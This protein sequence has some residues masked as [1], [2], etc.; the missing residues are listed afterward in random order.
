MREDFLHFI[1]QFQLFN[2]KDLFVE[3]NLLEILD[4]G[5]LNSDSGPDFLNA[6]IQIG[7][8]QWAGHVEIHKKSSDWYRHKHQDDPAYHNVIL[9]VVLEEDREIKVDGEILRTLVL[10]GRIFFQYQK[11]YEFLVNQTDEIR[12]SKFLENNNRILIRSMLD[13]LVVDRLQRKSEDFLSVLESQKGDWEEALLRWTFR[14]FGFKKNNEAFALLADLIGWKRLQKIADDQ[15]SIEALLFGAGGFLPGSQSDYAV[16]LK[17]EFERLKRKLDLGSRVI[18]VQQWQFFRMRPSNFPTIRIAQLA[19]FFNGKSSLLQAYLNFN[20]KSISWEIFNNEVTSFW[21]DNLH[22]GSEGVKQT[23]G[24]MGRKSRENL[25]INIIPSVLVAYSGY[26]GERKYLEKAIRLLEQIP[27]ENNKVIKKWRELGFEMEN[28][29]DSQGF[30][31]L[32]KNYCDKGLCLK[33]NQGIS[34]VKEGLE[35]Y[36]LA[37]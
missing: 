31:E 34:L 5:T 16:A 36:G 11:D 21:E 22:F 18:D 27:P 28:G 23:G 1:W 9:H 15:F 19:A 35:S 26:S 8:L 33:C 4:P 6:R 3:N 37:V 24:K 14:H 13:R 20:P 2:K 25:V 30:L 32:K 10:K 29:F 7:D 17:K 12:C